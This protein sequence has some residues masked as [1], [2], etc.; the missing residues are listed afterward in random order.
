MTRSSGKGTPS[1]RKVER[2]LILELWVKDNRTETKKAREPLLDENGIQRENENGDLFYRE[3]K[4]TSRVYPDGVR[5]I[6]I[7]KAKKPKKGSKTTSDY[8]V[9]DDSV[10]PNINPKLDI[11]LAKTTHPWG[12]FPVYIANSYE[13]LVSIWGFAAAEQVG[14]L[15]VKINQIVNKLITWVLNVMT[16]PLI[17]TKNCG[18]TKEMIESELAKA[19]RLILMPTSPN[20]KIEFMQIPNLPATFFQVLELIVRFFDR[21]YQIEDADRGTAPKGITAASAIVALQE[22]NQV[23]MQSKTSA[24]ESLAE[25][26]SKWAI[27]LWQNWGV[28]KEIVDVAGTVKEFVGIKYAGRKFNYIIETGSTTPRTSLQVQEQ[29]KWLWTTK[30][31]G[32]RGLLETLGWPGWKEEVERTAESQLDQA[33][34]L[35]IDAG[36]EEEDAIQLRNHLLEPQGGP[37]DLNKEKGGI[38]AVKPGTPKGAQGGAPP[39]EA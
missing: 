26:K 18:I 27:G 14:D 12:R 13:D 30:A 28:R 22:R 34:Q 17:V 20:A 4:K 9:I 19:G 7:T 25:N 32:Q 3:I 31:I 24:V 6:T 39:G 10:N 1:D 5:K 23:L 35:L 21:V 2:C 29:A 11:L 37:G 38:G 15:I 36:M 16:P 33:F 8:M